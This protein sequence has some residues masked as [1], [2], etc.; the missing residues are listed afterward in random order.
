MF[1]AGSFQEADILFE[2][3]KMRIGRSRAGAGSART[4]CKA[5]S[6]Y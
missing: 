1:V 3:G 5:V 2:F 6:I 4:G